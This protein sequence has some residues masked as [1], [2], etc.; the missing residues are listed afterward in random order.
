MERL[1]AETSAAEGEAVVVDNSAT[2]TS[3]KEK[4]NESTKM[5]SQN[6]KGRTTN[7]FFRR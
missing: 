6:E 4:E 1:A 5:D 7:T 2:T 3:S